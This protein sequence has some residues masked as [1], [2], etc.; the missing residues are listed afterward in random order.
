MTSDTNKGLCLEVLSGHWFSLLSG[1]PG[2]LSSPQLQTSLPIHSL[3]R[4]RFFFFSDEPDTPRDWGAFH[5]IK[6]LKKLDASVEFWYKW[7]FIPASL[8]CKVVIQVIVMSWDRWLFGLLHPRL[9]WRSAYSGGSKGCRG[10]SS[11]WGGALW[12]GRRRFLTQPR[13]LSRLYSMSPVICFWTKQS[14]WRLAKSLRWQ[15]T[16]AALSEDSSSVPRT[17][18]LICL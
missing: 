12:W 6:E 3:Y 18:T 2:L 14:G 15:R 17:H 9:Q 7:L 4:D 11:I 10:R 8:F 5:F 13:M 1:K 16:L